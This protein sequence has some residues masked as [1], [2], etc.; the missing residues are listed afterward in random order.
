MSTV[1]SNR[2]TAIPRFGP[3]DTTPDAMRVFVEIHRQ[4]SASRKWELVDGLYRFARELHA[5][6]ALMR[7]PELNAFEIRDDWMTMQP[8]DYP[9][10]AKGA[11]VNLP[12]DMRR[13]VQEVAAAFRNLEIPY[14][15]G[16]S[17]AS[18]IH[19]IP[20][21]TNDADFAVEP[22]PGKEEKLVA[23][24]GPE[25][26]LYLE[27]VKTAVRERASFN[28]ISTY[29][30]FKVDVFVRKERP[31]E[32]SLI[33]RRVPYVGAD[34]PIEVVTP[35]DIVLLKLEWFRLGNEIVDR[36]W[37]DVINVIRVRS[38]EL[39]LD[40]LARWASELGVDDLLEQALIEAES[41]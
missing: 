23:S 17:I 3:S 14:V 11:P 4:M 30:G 29:T 1:D 15:L 13:V 10:K 5:G 27:T 35:E 18:S 9:T 31:F 39:D 25:Y 32:R 37:N 36:Q 26:Y 19:G 7:R 38:G 41:F 12:P 2:K 24:F 33:Q 20:R 34:V 28:I 6:G 40:Y 22:F 21:S 16:G 8:H